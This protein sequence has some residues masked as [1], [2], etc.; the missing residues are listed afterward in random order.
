MLRVTKELQAYLSE[1]NHQSSKQQEIQTLEK[2]LEVYKNMQKRNISDRQRTMRKLTKQIAAKER[3]NQQYD[4]ELEEMSLSVVERGKIDEVNAD[5][6]AESGSAKRMQDII[7]RRKLVD[8]AKAQAQEIAVLRAEVER[9]R[10][11]TFPALTQLDQQ[12]L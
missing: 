10:M 12:H 4:E 11:R 3:E 1:E 6:S 9:L 8:L 2:T 5:Q 7:T